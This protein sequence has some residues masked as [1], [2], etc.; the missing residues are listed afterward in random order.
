[1]QGLQPEHDWSV[2]MAMHEPGSGFVMDYF[3][4]CYWKSSLSI[5]PGMEPDYFESYEAVD[6]WFEMMEEL[7]QSFR[8]PSAFLVRR[9]GA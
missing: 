6:R 8:Q 1:L 5:M 2:I 7:C 9:A 4:E 3:W